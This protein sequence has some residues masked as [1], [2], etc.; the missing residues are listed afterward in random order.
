MTVGFQ[1]AAKQQGGGG[2]EMDEVKRMLVETNPYFLAATAIVT[3][4]HMLY[5]SPVC[6]YGWL[7]ILPE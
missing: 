4:L 6:V 7:L 1:Q 3:V 5:V 2:G